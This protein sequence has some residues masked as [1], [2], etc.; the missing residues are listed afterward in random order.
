MFCLFIKLLFSFHLFLLVFSL[1]D[2]SFS[3][4]VHSVKNYSKTMHMYNNT[5]SGAFLKISS[6]VHQASPASWRLTSTPIFRP[7]SIFSEV[8]VDNSISTV[9][10]KNVGVSNV[11]C[12]VAVRGEQGQEGLGT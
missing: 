8:K 7:K 10:K 3:K 9:V 11:K 5:Y 4:I 6:C 12:A 2:L 1:K